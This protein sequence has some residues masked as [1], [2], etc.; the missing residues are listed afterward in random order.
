MSK[1]KRF[2]LIALGSAVALAIVPSAGVNA[3]TTNSTAAV[4]EVQ[5]VESA[6]D[7]ECDV[8]VEVAGGGFIITLPKRVTLSGDTFAAEYSVTVKGD[9][10]GTEVV[11]VVPDEYFF[12]KQPPKTDIK[13]GTAQ[14]KQQFTMDEL[15]TTGID[16]QTGETI[17]IGYTTTGEVFADG[18]D[19]NGDSTPDVGT[20]S[21]GDWEGVFKFTVSIEDVAQVDTVAD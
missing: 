3:A 16:D 7:K 18:R 10:S 12:M 13:S 14:E 17:N 19:T 15:A 9:I 1:L 20:L 11:R 5:H 8:D 2:N 4:N 6:E 21:A